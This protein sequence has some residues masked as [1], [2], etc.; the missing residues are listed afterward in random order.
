MTLKELA[1][2]VNEMRNA[3]REYLRTRATAAPEAS[4][5][6]EKAVDKV[7]KD[8]LDTSSRPLFGDGEG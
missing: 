7:I 5:A 2:L 4:K 8:I 3:Q 1:R 6:K